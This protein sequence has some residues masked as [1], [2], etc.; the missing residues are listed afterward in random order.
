MKQHVAADRWKWAISLFGASTFALWAICVPQ[1]IETIETGKHYSLGIE[2][3]HPVEEFG[4][5]SVILDELVPDGPLASAG[6]EVGDRVMLAPEEIHL[7]YGDP[8]S[9]VGIQAGEPQKEP[10]R[11]YEIIIPWLV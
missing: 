4:S 6:A 8:N 5:R 11:R 10:G 1:A 2:R 3:S 9:S 7:F